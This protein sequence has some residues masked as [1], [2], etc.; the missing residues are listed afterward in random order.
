MKKI[1]LSLCCLLVSCASLPE[2]V[3][4]IAAEEALDWELCKAYYRDHGQ[5]TVSRHAHI[6]GRPHSRWEVKE[7][8][9]DNVCY[10]YIRDWR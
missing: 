2:D 3:E 5:Y 7:D 6:R 8:L 1:L 9:L 10:T 4:Y